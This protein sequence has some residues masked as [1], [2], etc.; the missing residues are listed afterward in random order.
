MKSNVMF[1]RM[2]DKGVCRHKLMIK[3]EATGMRF[4]STCRKAGIIVMGILYVEILELVT[5]ITCKHYILIDLLKLYIPYM[6][7]PANS[8]TTYP[9]HVSKVDP[10]TITLCNVMFVQSHF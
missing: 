1:K 10:R 6:L 3:C 5:H 9:V 2:G 8:S 4:M 7:I